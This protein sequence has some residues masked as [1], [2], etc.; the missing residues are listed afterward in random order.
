MAAT[1]AA[2]R[3]ADATRLL[4]GTL[5]AAADVILK[6]LDKKLNSLRKWIK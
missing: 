4:G 3:F 6:F 2:T 5:G 1:P